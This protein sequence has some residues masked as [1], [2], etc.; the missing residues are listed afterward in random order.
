MISIGRPSHVHLRHAPLMWHDQIEELG[1]DAEELP[2]EGASCVRSNAA[3]EVALITVDFEQIERVDDILLFG[4]AQNGIIRDASCECEG[5][6]AEKW[7]GID[8]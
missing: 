4:R 2:E 6:C 1:I 8:D 3:I 5:R 7:S